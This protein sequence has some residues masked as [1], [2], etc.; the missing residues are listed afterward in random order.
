MNEGSQKS[1]ASPEPE[2]SEDDIPPRTRASRQTSSQKPN[3]RGQK[4]KGKAKEDSM[5]EAFRLFTHGSNGPITIQHLRAVAREI[6]AENDVDDDMLKAMILEANGGTGE[7]G[8]R[9]GVPWEN[10]AKIMRR[11][12]IKG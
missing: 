7:A 1:S 12:G 6:R 2:E 4:S 5:Y 10:F 11:A 3:A 9:E 8:V